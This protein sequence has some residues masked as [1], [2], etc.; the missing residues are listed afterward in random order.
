M[1]LDQLE[2]EAEI[3]I[4]T[5]ATTHDG[6]DLMCSDD[7]GKNSTWVDFQLNLILLLLLK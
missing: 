3:R 1:S 6:Y 5:A 4:Q 7:D 2:D